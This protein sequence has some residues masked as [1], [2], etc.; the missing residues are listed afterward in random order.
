MNVVRGHRLQA[1]IVIAILSGLRAGEL[2]GLRWKDVD[3]EAGILRV[4]QQ[5]VY[6]R[7]GLRLGPPKRDSSK[8]AVDVPPQVVAAL[9]R[10]AWRTR[11]GVSTTS[12]TPLPP[13]IA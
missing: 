3:F 12:G 2:L 9:R 8:R 1:L 5:L 7:S 13:S 4:R 11:R 10:R 6:P